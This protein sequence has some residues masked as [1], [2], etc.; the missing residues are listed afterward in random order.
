MVSHDVREAGDRVTVR[1]RGELDWRGRLRVEP[2]L[3]VA[4][5]RAAGRALVVDLTEVSFVD[6]SGVSLLIETAERARAAGLDL[7]IER[8]EA[9]VFRVFE[10]LGLDAVLPFASNAPK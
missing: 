2:V 10:V 4:V 3:E 6:S 8:P 9:R 1:L 7:E 5:D